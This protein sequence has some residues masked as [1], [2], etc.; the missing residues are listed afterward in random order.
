MI[1][2]YKFVIGE[3]YLMPRRNRTCELVQVLSRT[4]DTLTYKGKYT[5]LIETK[6]VFEHGKAE[7]VLG[8]HSPWEKQYMNARYPRGEMIEV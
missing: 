1:M 2:L 8:S 7:V 5:D 4:P 3:W 6:Y